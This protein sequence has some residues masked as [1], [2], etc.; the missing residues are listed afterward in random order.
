MLRSWLASGL[1]VVVAVVTLAGGY[2]WAASPAT[3]P[4]VVT[5]A[6]IHL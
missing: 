6:V 3:Y 2:Q 4:Q 1:G 5:M